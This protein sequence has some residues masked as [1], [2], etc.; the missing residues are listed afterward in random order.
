MDVLQRLQQGAV[1]TE[2]N[3]FDY[4]YY[5]TAI[6]NHSTLQYNMFQL[7]NGQGGKNLSDTNMTVGSQLSQGERLSI[8]ALK[9]QFFFV[10]AVTAAI[11]QEFITF[12]TN[13]TLEFIIMN[14]D[15]GRWTLLELFG[16]PAAG[17]NE[18]AVAGNADAMISI[19]RF[20]GIYPLNIPILLPALNT[21]NIRVTTQVPSSSISIDNCKLRV[22]LA[23]V[24]ERA[25]A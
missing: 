22:E 21:F 12:L 19:G 4:T 1:G 18:P 3:V 13:T 17:I 2:G 8:G 20:L 9:F 11:Y 5:D 25:T 24:L 14:Q 23:G 6:I 15:Y 16:I 10:A 7:A